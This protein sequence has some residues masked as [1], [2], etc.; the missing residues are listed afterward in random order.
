MALAFLLL[1][2]LLV[3]AMIV[4]FVFPPTRWAQMMDKTKDK[5]ASKQRKP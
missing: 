3:I 4:L 5:D 2:F 1:V